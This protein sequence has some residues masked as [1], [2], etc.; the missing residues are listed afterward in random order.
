MAASSTSSRAVPV[1]DE[2][3]DHDRHD[4][5]PINDIVY[6]VRNSKHANIGNTQ[7]YVDP[8]CMDLYIYA[9]IEMVQV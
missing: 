8:T 4:D 3:H 6:K 2:E 1:I 5:I 7:H 9:T